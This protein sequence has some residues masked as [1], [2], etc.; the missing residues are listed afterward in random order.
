MALDWI[1]FHQMRAGKRYMSSLTERDVPQWVQRTDD[2]L[3]RFGKSNDV[4]FLSGKDIP[5]ELQSIGIQ[6]IDVEAGTFRRVCYLWVGGFDHTLLSVERKTNGT[7]TICAR[8][9]DEN[10]EQVWPK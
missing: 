5:A 6:R 4:V 7:Y 2:L 9:D 1:L 8:F 10:R 3:L